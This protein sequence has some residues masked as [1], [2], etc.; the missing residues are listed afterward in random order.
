M[1]KISVRNCQSLWQGDS[2]L[3]LEVPKPLIYAVSE[4]QPLPYTLVACGVLASDN[5]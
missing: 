3:K 5:I 4:P 1:W 2:H